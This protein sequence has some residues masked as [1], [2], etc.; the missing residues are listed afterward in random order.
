MPETCST[1]R[2]HHEIEYA[3][4]NETGGAGNIGVNTFC[5]RRPPVSVNIN[6]SALLPVAPTGWCGEWAAAASARKKPIR[7]RRAPM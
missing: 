5:R 7:S 4:P 6:Q 1:C 3:I 2:F